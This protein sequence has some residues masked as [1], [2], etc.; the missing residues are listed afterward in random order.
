MTARALQL[1]RLAARGFRNLEP[2]E[3]DTDARFVVF[4][5]E[6]AQGKTN[7]LEAVYLLATLKPLRG[8]RVRELIRWGEDEASVAGDVRVDGLVHPYRVDL[9]PKGRTALLDGKRVGD[10]SAYFH[11]IRAIAF[12]PRDERIVSGEP[13]GRRRWLDRAAFTAAPAHLDVVRTYKRVLDQKSAA[14]KPPPG[15]AVMPELLDALDHQ[16]AVA[17]GRLIARRRANPG[18]PETDVLTRL[19]RGEGADAQ[20]SEIELMQN[21]IF[22]LNAGHETTTNLIGNGLA[23]LNDHPEERARLLERQP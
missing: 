2:F 17:G 5:G 7:A 19:I 22:I 9:G 12:T 8:R 18:D 20:L 4:H 11:T 6:N 15:A 14:L 16:L 1:T 23:L 3:L 13:A 21:C 10:L